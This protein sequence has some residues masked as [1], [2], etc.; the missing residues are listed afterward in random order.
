MSRN[1]VFNEFRD[2]KTLLMNSEMAL[3]LENLQQIHQ[4]AIEEQPS[5]EGLK[6]DSDNGDP[7][8]EIHQENEVRSHGPERYEVNLVELSEPMTY[9]E[10]VT[11]ENAEQWGRAIKEELRAHD[12]NGTWRLTT[13][14]KGKSTIGYKWVFKIKGTS[15]ENNLRYKARLCAKGFTQKPG[16][17]Y[18]EVFSPV[19]WFDTNQYEFF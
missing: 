15:S 10:A 4:A 1:V 5:E 3:L 11:G 7:E 12:K 17:D 18:K 16:I 19:Y 13:L 9:E 14:P 6:R 8:E 2:K